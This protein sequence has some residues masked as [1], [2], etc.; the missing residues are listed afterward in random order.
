MGRIGQILSFTRALIGA[1]KTSDVK[2]DRGGGDTRTPQ[3]FS[4]AGDDSYP[5]AGDYAQTV[6]QA[7]SGRDSVVGY[8]DPKNE[9]K[10]NAGEK[11]IYARDANSGATV[12]EVWLK[13]DGTATI[14]NNLGVITLQPDG[15]VNINGARITTGGDVITASGV[16]LANHPHSQGADS[17]GDAEVPTDPPTATE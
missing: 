8:V 3:H 6:D 14:F 10:A 15:E 1:T 7:G 12:V 13:N 17:D 16:S 5:L 4:D 9:Q 11:R 2:I